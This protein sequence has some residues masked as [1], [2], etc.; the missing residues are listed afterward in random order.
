[1]DCLFST[2]IG[3]YYL[4]LAGS[5]FSLNGLIVVILMTDKQ[6][7]T[8]SY[9]I[10]TNLCIA[11]MIQL[12]SQVVGGVMT[13][14]QSVYNYYLDRIF[15]IVIQSGW[16]LYEGITLTL[17]V[18]R[19]M[20]FTCP[21][22]IGNTITNLLLSLSWILWVTTAVILSL[23]SFGVTYEHDDLLYLWFYDTSAG[24]TTL[25]SIEPYFDMS[26]FAIVFVV[27]LMVVG[28]IV[29]VSTESS[30]AE[31]RILVVAIVSFFYDSFFT[32]WCFWGPTNLMDETSTFI[33]FNSSWIIECGLFAAL[34]PIFNAAVKKKIVGMFKRN[35][36]VVVSTVI[37][38]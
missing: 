25:Y 11:C 36:K 26:I 14:S 13:L 28:Y 30:K 17:A 8:S 22:P 35:K 32:I 24:S 1:M 33:V 19:L 29:K 15:G 27:Y 20:V 37:P 7:K 31:M 18:N 34:M 2:L 23:P 9:K 21:K 16:F 38:F 5:L 10:I 12:S 3:S 6:F 4:A